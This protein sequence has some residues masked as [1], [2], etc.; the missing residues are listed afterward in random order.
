M[1]TIMT[2]LS[3][4]RWEYLAMMVRKVIIPHRSTMLSPFNHFVLQKASIANT[5]TQYLFF[6]AML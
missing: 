1:M 4:Y 6:F 3:Y 2:T 5:K